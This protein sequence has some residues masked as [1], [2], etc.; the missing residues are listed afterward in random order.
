MRASYRTTIA[1]DN[2]TLIES[3]LT[4]SAGIDRELSDDVQGNSELYEGSPWGRELSDNVGGGY[5]RVCRE[6][7]DDRGHDIRVTPC[8]WQHVLAV[9]TISG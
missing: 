9:V 2:S 4:T 1:G 5:L 6:L 7:A 3:C 8:M